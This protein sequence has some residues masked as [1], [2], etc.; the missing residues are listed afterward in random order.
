MKN[1]LTRIFLLV[2]SIGYLSALKAQTPS[3]DLLMQKRE[4][5]VAL[6]YDAGSWDQYWEGARLRSNANIG[7]FSKKAA[8]SMV[9]YGITNKINLIATLPYIQT[10]AT[11]GQLKG[12]SGIQ[13]LNIAIK[14]EIFNQQVGPG[15][16]SFLA[17]GGF[18]T[19]VSN[20][21]SDY[22][23][24]SL[25][26]GTNEWSL[27]GILQYRFDNGIYVRG[28]AAHLWRGQTKVERN[29]YYNNG[30]YYS[31]WMD[32]PN[33]LNY[34]CSVG[35]WLFNSA[36]KIEANYMGL[37]STSGDDIRIYNSPQPTNKVEV[38]QVGFFAQYYFKT[39]KPLQGFGVIAS[40]SKMI[41]GRNM[42]QFQNYGFGITYQ[43]KI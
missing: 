8:T 11:G 33:A 17:T 20:Y 22:Q 31:Q 40:Y 3:D 39:I 23:P 16:I 25:G 21:L 1:H 13:D 34:N 28:A 15:K 24:F 30:A 32:V 36:L 42:G 43:F 26:L 4:F 37:R 14:G 12:A 38:D 5:C 35:T 7:T 9:A 18:A 19:P 41:H 2:L 6:L 29:F 10:E 27:R